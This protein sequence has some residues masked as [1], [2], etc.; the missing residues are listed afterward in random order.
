[1]ELNRIIYILVFVISF[2]GI[3]NYLAPR[4]YACECKGSTVEESFRKHDAVFEGKVLKIQEDSEKGQAILFEV[5]TN[6]KGAN[7]SQIIIYTNLGS[8]MVPFTKG[9]S[10]L[11]FSSKRGTTGQLYTSDCSGT[12]QLQR[13]ENDVSVLSHIAKGQVP[14]KQV[15]V[16]HA[17]PNDR[18]T[19]RIII[20]LGLALLVMGTWVLIIRNIRKK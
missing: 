6:W 4:I 18:R 7:T 15:D 1:M 13:A 8:C 17:M 10:Y 19:N 3:L 11:V 16:E 9:E 14:T 20:I 12:K 5:K 2:G